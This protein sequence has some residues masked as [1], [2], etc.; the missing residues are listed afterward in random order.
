M[1]TAFIYV[2]LLSDNPELLR[3]I[4]GSLNPARLDKIAQPPG[5]PGINGT[6]I[7]NEVCYVASLNAYYPKIAELVTEG[8]PAD[9][10]LIARALFAVQVASGFAGGTDLNKLCVDL[11]PTLLNGLFQ[12]FTAPDAKTGNQI[13]DYVCG[14]AKRGN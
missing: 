12:G 2:T 7:R 14:V 13:Q 10:P 8:Q 4:C 5:Y 3:E 9:V 1:T 6:A 11:N